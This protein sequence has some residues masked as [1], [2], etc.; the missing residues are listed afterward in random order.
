MGERAL[1]WPFARRET[2][3]S[4]SVQDHLRRYFEAHEGELPGAGLHSRVIR[5]VEKPLIELTLEATGGNQLKAARVLGINRNTL[6]KKIQEL[7]VS[8]S[9]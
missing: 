2:S 5:E 7:G 8:L 1:R 4:D 6:R 3:L 9:S